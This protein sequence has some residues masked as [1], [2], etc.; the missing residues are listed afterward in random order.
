MVLCFVLPL[1]II[2]YPIKARPTWCLWSM[3]S[4]KCIFFYGVDLVLVFFSLI[5]SIFYSYFTP[6]NEGSIFYPALKNSCINF[7]KRFNRPSL[8]EKL[9]TSLLAYILPQKITFSQWATKHLSHFCFLKE[10][11][12]SWSGRE[13]LN[14]F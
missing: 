14:V 3:L 10:L 2:S 9:K 4:I 6:T 7:P 11:L 13:G 8:S 1:H 12:F 5:S